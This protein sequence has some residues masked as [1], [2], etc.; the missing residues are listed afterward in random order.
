MEYWEA[1]DSEDMK[2]DS[3]SLVVL[4]A[5]PRSVIKTFVIFKLLLPETSYDPFIELQDANPSKEL[6]F[7]KVISI[8]GIELGTQWSELSEYPSKTQWD[9][10]FLSGWLLEDTLRQLV[11]LGVWLGSSFLQAD[12]LINER[13]SVEIN[14]DFIIKVL[15]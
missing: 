10:R 1:V 9:W 12:R 5:Q 15:I 7:E 8:S 3:H 13:I 2:V 11:E 6:E 14:N 4:S